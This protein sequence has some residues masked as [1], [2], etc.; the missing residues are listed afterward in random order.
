MKEL[1]Q[2]E[3]ELKVVI[4]NIKRVKQF[5]KDNEKEKWKPYASQVFGELKHRLT[6]LKPTITRVTSKST[7]NL[8]SK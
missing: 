2:L 3:Q 7:Y 6:A 5:K 4:D 1:D 8:F